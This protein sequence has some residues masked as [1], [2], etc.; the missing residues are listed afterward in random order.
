MPKTIRVCWNPDEHRHEIK[1]GKVHLPVQD[2]ETGWEPLPP[3]GTRILGVSLG[4]DAAAQLLW[5]AHQIGIPPE[6]D[7]KGW[8]WWTLPSHRIVKVE[9]FD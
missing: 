3:D 2:L 7:A 5:E 1:L 8:L 9:S 4:T 6:V